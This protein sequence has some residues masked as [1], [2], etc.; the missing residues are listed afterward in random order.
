MR[1]AYEEKDGVGSVI[2]VDTKG[3]RISGYLSSFNNIDSHNDTITPNAFDKTVRERKEQILFLNQH[4]WEQPHGFF[5][6]LEPD[7]RGLKFLSYPLPNTT[8]SNDAIELYDAGIIAD[9]SI[10]FIPVKWDWNDDTQ[11]RTLKEIKLFEGSNVTV[12]ADRN[13]PYLGRKAMTIEEIN[14]QTKRIT[15]M[16]R[17]GTVTDQTFIQL[18]IALKQLQMESYERG[19]V[20]ALKEPDTS[21]DQSQKNAELA[22]AIE[23]FNQTIKI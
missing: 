20:D 16:L 4:S 1:N 12:G 22:R 14:D 8:Y 3:R 2:D 7:E 21:T 13:T 18:E 6:E 11:I 17:N 23:F 10:G 19:R 15:K 5:M 9:H